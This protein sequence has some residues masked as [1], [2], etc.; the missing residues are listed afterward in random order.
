MQMASMTFRQDITDS[1]ALD[2]ELFN[3]ACEVAH[4]IPNVSFLSKYQKNL[5]FIG[6]AI[7][8]E[9]LWTICKFRQIY[10]YCPQ[11]VGCFRK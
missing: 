4:S 2:R 1:K 6:L 3:V 11:F 9:N 5:T 7:L 10:P 8:L